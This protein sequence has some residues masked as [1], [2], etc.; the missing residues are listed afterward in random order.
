M[1]KLK[2]W[3]IGPMLEKA[4]CHGVS[5]YGSRNNSIFKRI[6]W[7]LFYV[8]T[9]ELI[10]LCQGILRLPYLFNT[11]FYFHH[12]QQEMLSHH[13]HLLFLFLL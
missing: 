7:N 8:V 1:R 13:F 5:L 11:V 9:L 12:E 6:S 2:Y 10:Y 3:L 4:Q